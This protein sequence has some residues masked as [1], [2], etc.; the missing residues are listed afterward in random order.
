MENALQKF[1]E[2]IKSFPEDSLPSVAI[3]SHDNPDPD[4]IGSALGMQ[5][6][7]KLWNPSIKT[8]I[9]YGGEIS[10]PQNKTMVNILNVNPTNKQDVKDLNEIAKVFVV[11]DSLPDRSLQGIECAFTVDHHKGDTK[12]SKFK[13]IRMVGA[14]SSIVWEYF[15]QE[16]LVLDKDSDE[17]CDI[18][19]ALVVGIKTDTSDLSSDNV[20]DLDFE[21]YK[22][23][24]GFVNQRKLALIIKYPLPP[25][26]FELRS[27]LDQ[28]G[29]S[30][31]DSGVFIGGIGYIV[32]SK[33]D[34]LPTIA[35]ER[36]RVEGTDTAFIY[37]IVG[38]N[39][40]LSVRSNG[41]SLDVNTIC[42][43]LFGKE[44]GGGKMGAGAVRM[45]MGIL[46]IENDPPEIQQ[47]MWEAIR[48]KML[49]KIQAEMS[50]YR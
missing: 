41:L 17:D 29:N 35:E 48:D 38:G 45:P 39:I 2:Y 32:P 34:A 50:R 21:A 47:K 9:L 12:K 10:H 23:L 16:Q 25:Y 24:I 1:K 40:E 15:Q 28:E 20:T 30:L 11:V 42:Q 13:D 26:H 46:S 22:H 6:L 19:T 33:R 18:A 14:A 37:A 27:R 5:R 36:A 43:N 7:I 31:T 49:H 44:F 3:V 4:S 8:T